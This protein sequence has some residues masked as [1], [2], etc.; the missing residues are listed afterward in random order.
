MSCEGEASEPNRQLQ[1][2]I[3][4]LEGV[5]VSDGGL[6]PAEDLGAGSQLVGGAGAASGHD[7]RVAGEVVDLLKER[8][9]VA[10]PVAKGEQV[11][12]V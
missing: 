11:G 4:Y 5:H 7:L 6:V 8:D 2:R 9:V 1:D 12:L 3:T 10:G